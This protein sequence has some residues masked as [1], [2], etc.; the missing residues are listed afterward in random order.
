MDLQSPLSS[1]LV[2]VIWC[3]TTEKENVRN[4]VIVRS[5][6]LLYQVNAR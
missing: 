1:L 4:I 2:Q 6:Q 3:A 5:A